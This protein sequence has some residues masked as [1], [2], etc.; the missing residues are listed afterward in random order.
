MTN[1]GDGVK[2]IYLSYIDMVDCMAAPGVPETKITIF[3]PNY[4]MF[5]NGCRLI[6]INDK[7]GL[8]TFVN[9]ELLPYDFM[10]A[11]TCR[12]MHH[13]GFI[14]NRSY[15]DAKEIANFGDEDYDFDYGILNYVN[16]VIS[17]IEAYKNNKKDTITLV[18]YLPDSGC[19]TVVEYKDDEDFLEKTKDEREWWLEQNSVI[20]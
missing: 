10:N 6:S 13:G 4:G 1:Y 9:H 20:S 15:V 2:Q 7:K 14:V 3:K 8:E 18:A 19:C 17:S 12:G 11:V 5:T 16:A